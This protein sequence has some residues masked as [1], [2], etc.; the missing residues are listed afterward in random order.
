MGDDY[1]TPAQVRRLER[2]VA[3]LEPFRKVNRIVEVGAG[4]GWFLSKAARLGWETWAVEINQS[5]LERLGRMEVHKVLVEPAETFAAPDDHFDVVRIW[6]VIEHLESPAACA[7]N[8]YRV[9]RPGGLLRLSTTNFASLSRWV[10]GPEW[11][12]LNGADHI[13]LFEPPTIRRLLAEAGFSVIEVRTRSF[14]L[15]RKLYQPEQ[16]LPPRVRL[17]GLFRK[18]IDEAIGLTRFGHQ[19]IVTALKPEL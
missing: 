6:D 9:L 3:L 13:V 4:W 17:P 1:L 7:R 16:I 10:N 12:Y 14:N 15:R 8:M 5:A 2:E 19:M 11:V 18:V